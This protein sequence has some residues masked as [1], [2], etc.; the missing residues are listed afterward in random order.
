MKIHGLQRYSRNTTL[1]HIDLYLVFSTFISNSTKYFQFNLQETFSFAKIYLPSLLRDS[2]SYKKV[3]DGRELP[4]SQDLKIS[5][6]HFWR[7][8]QGLKWVLNFFFRKK[9]DEIVYMQSGKERTLGQILKRRQNSNWD[10]H[11]CA[12]VLER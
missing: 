4:F 11:Y 7:I 5:P 9:V 2:S 12:N 1:V 6:Y 3:C 10:R 8:F